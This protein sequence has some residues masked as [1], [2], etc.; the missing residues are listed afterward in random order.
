MQDLITRSALNK[1]TMRHGHLLEM[2]GITTVDPVFEEDDLKNPQGQVLTFDQYKELSAND[3]RFKLPKITEADISDKSKGDFLSKLIAILQTTWFILQCIARG[4]QKLAITELEL[5]TLALASLNAV[6]YAFWWNKPLGVQEP[7]RIYFKT[8]AKAEEQLD[9][10]N[11]TPVISA[12][13]VLSQVGKHLKVFGILLLNLLLHPCEDGI[14]NGI[15]TGLFMLVFGV[16]VFLFI[17]FALCILVPFPLGVILLMKILKTSPVTEDL[18]DSRGLIAA[19]ILHSLRKFRY[20]LTSYIASV[21]EKWLTKL[22]DDPEDFSCSGFFKGWLFLLP[23]LFFFLLATTICLLPLFAL[24]SLVSFIFTAVFG[25]ITS[26]SVA[27]GATHVPSFYA[28]ATKSDKYSRMLVFAFFGVIFGG[29][30][31]IGWNFQYPTQFEQHLWRATSLAITVIPF[32]VAPIDYILE[33]FEL[34]KGFGKVARLVLD[35][36]MTILLFV[37]VPA[38]LSLIA[39]ALALMR[40]QPQAAYLAVDWTQYIPHIF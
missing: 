36:I 3:A 17:C 26:D 28:P 8:E 14:C 16:P 40:E 37:Y 5:V 29:L 39:Q 21:S 32:I 30:H 15:C 4:Q 18:S 1:W 7:I 20:R 35:L 9:A 23:V 2:G 11:E 27:P 19:Q 31:C 13:Y 6:T 12:Y 25:I 34:N 22:L 38:R 33:N 24:V 10:S